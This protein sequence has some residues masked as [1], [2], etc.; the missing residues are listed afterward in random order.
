MSPLALALTLVRS[1][2]ASLAVLLARSLVLI[3]LALSP[4][5]RREIVCNCRAVLGRA[6]RAFWLRNA[7]Q[8]GFNLAMM[9]RIDSHPVRRLIDNAS[10]DSDNKKLWLSTQRIPLVMASFH[11]GMWECL[12]VIFRSRGFH[13]KVVVGGQRDRVLDRVLL[14]LRSVRRVR[15]FGGARVIELSSWNSGVTLLGAMLDNTT[16]GPMVEA[17]AA[18]VTMRMPALA[19]RRAATRSTDGRSVSGDVIPLFCTF[20]RGGMRIR[21]YEPGNEAHAL[22]CLLREVRRR[23]ADWVFWG[24]SGALG[25]A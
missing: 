19:F 18:G 15:S 2:P 9:A 21:V 3:R 22:G 12:P 25:T 20:E 10:I 13:V 4:S 8:V 17:R 5:S 16:R 7:W 14:R 24:K 23:P 11:Y 1:L 6:P